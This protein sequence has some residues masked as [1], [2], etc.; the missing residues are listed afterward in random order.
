VFSSHLNWFFGEEAREVRQQYRSEYV[1][2]DNVE[3]LFIRI[4]FERRAKR[5]QREIDGKKFPNVGIFNK[6][7]CAFSGLR[8]RARPVRNIFY[9]KK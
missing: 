9:K 3:V 4:S 2:A 5:L 6:F 7:L 1:Y 8:E